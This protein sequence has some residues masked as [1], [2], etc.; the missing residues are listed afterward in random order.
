M[1]KV[2]TCLVP[3]IAVLELGQAFRDGA[4][5]YGPYNWRTDPVK[6]TVYLD[7]IARHLALYKAGQDRASDSNVHHLTSVMSGCAILLD[8]A[9]NGTLQDDRYK[10][11]NPELLEQA[12]EEFKKANENE[13]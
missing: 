9:L 4:A 7:A 12:L 8:A 13:D 6:T 3:D 11:E 1:A 2:S 10:M 5:K